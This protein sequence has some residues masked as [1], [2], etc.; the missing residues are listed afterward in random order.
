MLV[1]LAVIVAHQTEILTGRKDDP[2]IVI[3]EIAGM[4]VTLVQIPPTGQAILIGF[5][6]FRFFDIVKIYPAKLLAERLRGGYGVVMDDIAAGIYANLSLRLVLH[7]M[8]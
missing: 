3:D 6:L 7:L 8:G 4:A 5:L 2:R 1:I